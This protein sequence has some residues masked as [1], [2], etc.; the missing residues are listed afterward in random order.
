MRIGE[1]WE[2]DGKICENCEDRGATLVRICG[3]DYGHY[4]HNLQQ[5]HWC[6]GI[7]NMIF[8]GEGIGDLVK[9]KY[10]DNEL[11]GI[12]VMARE[13]FLLIWRPCYNKAIA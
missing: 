10:V 5:I 9:Y 2:S 1:I 7:T 8:L 3:F 12:H 11:V 6:N 13:A 4:A